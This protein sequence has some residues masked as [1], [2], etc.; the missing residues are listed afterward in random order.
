M[1][2]GIENDGW[3]GDKEVEALSPPQEKSSSFL[4]PYSF[5]G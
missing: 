5:F 1:G 3:E 4:I 2:L